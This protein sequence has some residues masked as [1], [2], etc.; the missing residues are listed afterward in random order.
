MSQIYHNNAATNEKVRK[1]IRSSSS[2]INEL[3]NKYSISPDTVIKWKSRDSFKDKSSK[4]NKIEYALN[5]IEES[6]I[7]SLRKTAWMPVSAILEIVEPQNDNYNDSNIYRT[8]CRNNINT[9]PEKKKD[10]AKKFKEYKPGFIHIDVTY[11]PKIKGEKK[12]LFVAIDRVT[13]IIYYKIYPNKDSI[14]SNKFLEECKNFFLMVI[15]HILTDNGGEFINNK[16]KENCKNSDI[17][18]RNTKPYTLKTNG[19]VESS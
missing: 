8:F 3:T 15:T 11:L 16:F 17:K 14:C 6:V 4:P 7:I 12:Y 10:E 18:A 1:E 19:M 2:S 13:R 5:E 9:I